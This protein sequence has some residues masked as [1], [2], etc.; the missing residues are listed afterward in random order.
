M[1]QKVCPLS[2]FAVVMGFA[3][4]LTG[5]SLMGGNSTKSGPLPEQATT[6]GLQGAEDKLDSLTDKRI[7]RVA[8][9]VVLAENAVSKSEPDKSDIAVA[10]S[11]LKIA[12][13]MTGEP[14]KADLD[15]ANARAQK[16]LA[17][18]PDDA[19]K[20]VA[21][22]IITAEALRKEIESANSRYEQEKARKQADF[23]AKL[24]EKEIEIQK[25]KMELEQERIANDME[26]WTWVGIGMFTVGMLLTFLAPFP[27]LKK[28]GM[29]LTLTGIICGSFPVIGN[30][31]WFKYAIG[32]T[33][34][35]IVI[36]MLV[37]MFF[38]K[39]KC[40]VDKSSVDISSDSSGQSNDNH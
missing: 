32:G 38:F 9:S 27:M 3:M 26:R 40:E 17:G 15:Y 13:A 25:R 1:S 12:R 30:E 28:A 21:Q 18:S 11:E 19:Q 23:E 29:A 24:K 14:T 37:Q 6:V 7:S 36:A 39:P 34:G 16:M 31:P 8:A 4:V 33:I 2:L 5:C 22:G 35:L 20:I 10:K